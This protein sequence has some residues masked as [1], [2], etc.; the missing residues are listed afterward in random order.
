[1]VGNKNKVKRARHM[2][3]LYRE[4]AEEAR[5]PPFPEVPPEG[6]YQILGNMPTDEEAIPPI[7]TWLPQYWWSQW[8]EMYQG[9]QRQYVRP[10]SSQLIPWDTQHSLLGD[11]NGAWDPYVVPGCFGYSS[12]GYEWARQPPLACHRIR[13]DGHLEVFIPETWGTD[14]GPPLPPAL[15]PNTLQFTRNIDNR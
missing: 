3:R 6:C 1:M 8:A 14:N 9:R 13:S 2:E 10:G 5:L 15:I 7:P 4:L 12:D 11:F